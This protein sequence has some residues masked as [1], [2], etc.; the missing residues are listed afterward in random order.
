M[1]SLAHSQTCYDVLRV[2]RHASAAAI[3]AAWRAQVMRL[4]P[5]RAPDDR[6][7]SEAQLREI[8]RAYGILKDPAA[9]AAY[10][11]ALARTSPPAPAP[12]LRLRPQKRRGKKPSR[13]KTA[14]G[15]MRE[16]LWP[17]ASAEAR[18]GR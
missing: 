5:D 2:P 6:I 10:D 13:W 11:A 18:H 16:I 17:L 8:N 12:S 14:A 9:R 15:L 3:R 4:H 7:R 1:M